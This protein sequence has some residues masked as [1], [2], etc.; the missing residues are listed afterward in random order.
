MA[1]ILKPKIQATGLMDAF[2]LGVFKSVSERALSP[3]IGNSSLQSGA[4]KLVGGGVLNSLSR[5]KHVNLLSS[6]VIVDGI[7][8]VVHSLLGAALGGAGAGDAG[9]DW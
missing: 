7:E 4:I 8:D 2:E 9:G 3:V 6:A 1:K 5:N